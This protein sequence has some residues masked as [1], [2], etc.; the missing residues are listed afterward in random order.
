MLWTP[1]LYGPEESL[2]PG[3]SAQHR[4]ATCHHEHILDHPPSPLHPTFHLGNTHRPEERDQ[5]PERTQSNCSRPST[6]TIGRENHMP[7]L[8]RK[9][10][11][12]H[13]ACQ[14]EER[15]Q[16]RQSN[17]RA[18]DW[19]TVSARYR[20]IQGGEPNIW[21]MPQLWIKVGLLIRRGLRCHGRHS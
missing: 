12:V 17:R 18:I 1:D 3:E 14:G 5:I 15:D 21:T 2:S 10:K 20:T 7:A 16:R 11:G 9:G 13:F 8:H 6:T 4:K 19:R